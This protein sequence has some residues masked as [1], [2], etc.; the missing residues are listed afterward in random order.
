MF[1]NLR[2][3]KLIV[4]GF[5]MITSVGDLLAT[6]YIFCIL[7]IIF[8]HGCKLDRLKVENVAYVPPGNRT[9]KIVENMVIIDRG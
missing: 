3:I 2:L 8:S 1:P 5:G 7:G 6:C 4:L 9:G